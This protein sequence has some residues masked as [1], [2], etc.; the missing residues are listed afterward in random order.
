MWQFM[1]FS[2][3]LEEELPALFY[4]YFTV[5]FAVHEV[6]NSDISSK[7]EAT[8]RSKYLFIRNLLPAE[9]LQNT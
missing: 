1:S 3:A 2:E 4:V 8:E 7:T 6:E 9:S 5:F